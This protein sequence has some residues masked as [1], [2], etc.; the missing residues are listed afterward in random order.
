VGEGWQ[1]SKCLNTSRHDNRSGARAAAVV[2]FNPK[3]VSVASER[4]HKS[5]IHIWNCVAL[6]P[7]PVFDEV[8]QRHGLLVLIS[9]ISNVAV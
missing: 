9:G 4:L 8:W 6:Y 1:M 5:W 2:E 7:A 3:L